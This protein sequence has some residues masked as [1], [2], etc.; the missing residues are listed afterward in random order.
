MKFRPVRGGLEDAM[1]EVVEVGT[2]DDLRKLVPEYMLKPDADGFILIR[3]K[4]QGFDERIGW[5]SHLLTVNG[6]PF[7]YLDG[8]LQNLNLAFDP[9]PLFM[10]DSKTKA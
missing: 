5:D 6:E 7:G 10:Y 3:A 8:P 1:K 4:S 9:V 2:T